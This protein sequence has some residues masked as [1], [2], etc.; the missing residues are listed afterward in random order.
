MCP[1]LV[2][3]IDSGVIT[4]CSSAADAVT[5]LNVDPGS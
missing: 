1:G 5:I 4:C 2:S 3:T